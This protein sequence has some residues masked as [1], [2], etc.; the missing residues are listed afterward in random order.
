MA[1]RISVRVSS[2]KGAD[3]ALRLLV[4]KAR[5][6][7]TRKALAAVKFTLEYATQYT[8]K[9]SGEAT[10]S[11][12]V[13]LHQPAAYS[14]ATPNTG[15]FPEQKYEQGLLGADAGN[16]NRKVVDE[17]MR[18]IRSDISAALKT[19]GR[20]K[21]YISN[22]SAHSRL[23]LEGSGD[24]EQILREVNHEYRT[25]KEIQSV[26]KHRVGIAGSR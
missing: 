3:R 15:N 19:K 23:W 2:R 13:S 11:W 5:E 21:V 9:W 8:P 22:T 17:Q 25:L 26:L 12:V 10:A 7:V 1:S 6:G 18:N 4:E 24:P 14:A 16:L 20:L